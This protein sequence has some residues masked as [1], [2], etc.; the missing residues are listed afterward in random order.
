MVQLLQDV[1][2]DVGLTAAHER[3]IE[4]LGTEVSEKLL[5]IHESLRRITLTKPSQE[6]FVGNLCEYPT[7]PPSEFETKIRPFAMKASF[8]VPRRDVEDGSLNISIEPHFH[9]YCRVFPTF[10]EQTEFARK[11]IPI[12]RTIEDYVAKREDFYIELALA[13]NRLDFDGH[14]LKVDLAPILALPSRERIYEDEW[15]TELSELRRTAEESSSSFRTRP[16]RGTKGTIESDEISVLTLG[17]ESGYQQELLRFTGSKMKTPWKFRARVLVRPHSDAEYR[18]D[19]VLENATTMVA[20]GKRELELFNAR[21]RTTLSK[22]CITPFIIDYVHDGYR[23]NG[24][25]EAKGVNCFPVVRG[26]CIEALPIPVF[27]QTRVYAKDHVGLSGDPVSLSFSSL[28][29]DPIPILREV[30]AGMRRQLEDYSRLL[31][32]GK[33]HLNQEEFLDDTRRFEKETRRFETGLGSLEGNPEALRAFRLMNEV[34]H[35]AG[36]EIG[37]GSWRLFQLVFIVMNVTD[38]LSESGQDVVEIVSVFTG[39]GKTEAYLGLVLFAAFLDRLKGKSFGITAWTKFPLRMLSLQQLERIAHVFVHADQVKEENKIEG[40]SLTIGYFV[41]GENRPNRVASIIDTIREVGEKDAPYRI[42]TNCPIC[43]S[44][45]VLKADVKAQRVYHY[46]PK[47]AKHLPIVL[48]DDEIYR[49]LPTFVISTLDKL[50]I[51]AFQPNFRAMLGA[52]ISRCPV[53]GFTSKPWCAVYGCKEKLLGVDQADPAPSIL[54][55]DELHMIRE[56]LGTIDSHFETTLETIQKELTKRWSSGGKPRGLKVIAATATISGAERQVDHLYAKNVAIFPA[57][58]PQVPDTHPYQH[59]FYFAPSTELHVQIVGIIPHNKSTKYALQRT[60]RYVWESLTSW[61]K[62][63]SSLAAKL[64]LQQEET[65]NLLAHYLRLVSYHQTRR[66]ANTIEEG[67]DNE[68]NPWLAEQG[69]QKLNTYMLTSERSIEQIRNLM[70]EIQATT[71]S[72]QKDLIL[73]TKLISHGIDLDNLNLMFFQGMPRSVFEY[74]QAKSRIARKFPGLVYVVF[75]PNRERD[76]SYYH[77]FQTFHKVINHMIEEIPLSRWAKRSIDVTLPSLL[78]AS[79]LTNYSDLVRDDLRQSE[80][81]RRH[82]NREFDVDDVIELLGRAL[83]VDKDPTCYFKG[84]IDEKVRTFLDFLSNSTAKYLPDAFREGKIDLLL[85]MRAVEE[86]I[87]VIP[88]GEQEYTALRF[89]FAR[90]E[91]FDEDNP[92]VEQSEKEKKKEMREA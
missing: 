68:V 16:K 67:I 81:L 19:V 1:K 86:E 29:Q 12:N 72:N 8:L 7:D 60:I 42:I 56:E 11:K 84:Q 40:D 61:N 83:L 39:A 64:D 4:L 14:S 32:Q 47:C 80:R 24:A 2:N 37:F 38:V 55:Q 91:F 15:E 65:G 5:G 92:P 9:V 58:P 74:I 71:S 31:E 75:Y 52:R 17:S 51:A 63:L 44:Q 70:D 69:F 36:K 82:L 26:S 73:A 27:N 90:S 22:S 54:I 28:A 46:C 66:D 49:V 88:L 13:Y 85:G 89:G 59:S 43:K 3:F 30:L 20:P 35:R 76:Q 23:R 77:Y 18:V 57:E 25:I 62:N 53:H 78:V 41:G 48:S 21:F 10:E 50:T 87:D 34:F 33:T 79:L 45:I 6:I